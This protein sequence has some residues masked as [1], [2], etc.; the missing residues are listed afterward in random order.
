MTG[1][2]DHRVSKESRVV[3]GWPDL[4][5]CVAGGL[6]LVVSAL[7]VETFQVSEVERVTFVALNEYSVLPFVLVWPVMQLGNILVVP[8]TALIAAIRRRWRLGMGILIGGLG[9]YLL[10]KGVKNVVGRGRPDTLLSGVDI[11]G[12]ASRGSGFVS[13]HAAV[14][15]VIV[16]LL[17]PYLGR[18]G[19]IAAVILAGIVCLSRVYVGSHLPLD[20]LG[21]IGLGLAVGGAV[22]LALG[23]PA[24][25]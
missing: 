19:R 18:R 25:C 15:T 3:R 7:P 22:R 14:V 4:T 1:P 17:W 24:P 10:A 9:V 6:I 16:V 13:G 21:G 5:L 20:I 23:R 2:A 8:A 11:R 12:E